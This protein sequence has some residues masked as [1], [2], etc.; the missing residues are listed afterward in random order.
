MCSSSYYSNKPIEIQSVYILPHRHRHR[1]R[2]RVARQG[3]FAQLAAH[4]GHL[5][6][7]EWSGR[8]EHVVAVDPDCA[9]PQ[10]RRQGVGLLNVARPNGGGQAVWRVIR[11]SSDLVEALELENRHYGAK[12]LFFGDRH[13]VGDFGEECRLDIVTAI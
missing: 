9:G 2:L 10:L 11:T 7:A 1:L 5:E 13:V 4:A 6:A 3:S 8:V 12:N